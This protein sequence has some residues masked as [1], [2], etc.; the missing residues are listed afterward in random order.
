M[1]KQP[2]ITDA[3]RKRILDSFWILFRNKPIDKITVAQISKGA[4]IH[5]SSFYRYFQDVY[6]VLD[7]F[8]KDLLDSLRKE[9]KPIF[10]NTDLSLP[11]Y[12]ELTAPVLM[13][14]SDKI[15]RLLNDSSS[16]FIQQFF[17][18]IR[19][20][21]SDKLDLSVSEIEQN[22]IESFI[23]SMMMNNFNYWYEHQD[24]CS[25]TEINTFGQ[26]IL[27]SGISELFCNMN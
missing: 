13:K 11:V 8:E 20:N 21:I 18:E 2:E 6:M 4:E 14:Y 24:I 22:Y 15:Y 1:N 3:T 26:K 17:S 23:T 12:I 25:L 16:K 19:H 10:E 7:E 5:R 27:F 9:I